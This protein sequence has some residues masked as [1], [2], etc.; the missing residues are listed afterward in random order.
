M[1][2][3]P[4]HASGSGPDRRRDMDSR[5]PA[6]RD[7]PPMKRPRG[8]YSPRSDMPRSSDSRSFSR[9]GGFRGSR[10]GPMRG[11]RGMGRG[12]PASRH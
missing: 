1:A 5:R 8:D 9:G 10:G 11:G 3:P 4:S 12:G 7:E 6:A 2:P